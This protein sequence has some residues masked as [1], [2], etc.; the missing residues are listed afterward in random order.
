[1]PLYLT[2]NEAQVAHFFTR[3]RED[4]SDCLLWTGA[5]QK[6]HGYGLHSWWVEGRSRTRRA[7]RLMWELTQGPIPDG[8]LVLHDCDVRLCGRHLHL[9]TTQDNLRERDERGRQ[10][11]GVRVNTAKLTPVQV[12]EIRSRVGETNVALAREFGV[13]DTNIIDIRRGRIWKGLL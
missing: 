3:W 8:L 6:V 10:V 5:V 1:M 11:R 13:S 12:R 9:G 7:H 4:P 2:M